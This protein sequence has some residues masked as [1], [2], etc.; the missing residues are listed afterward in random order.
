MAIG[1]FGLLLVTAVANLK[2]TLGFK[3]EQE[4]ATIP[5]WK[6]EEIRAFPKME[7]VLTILPAPSK[8]LNLKLVLVQSVSILEQNQLVSQKNGCGFLSLFKLKSLK[9][10]IM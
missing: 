5:R 8:K 6:M 7:T 3:T 4:H 10:D 2:M 1:V 9:G